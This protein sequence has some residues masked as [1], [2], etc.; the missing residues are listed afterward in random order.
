MTEL[1]FMKNNSSPTMKKKVMILF[2]HKINLEVNN[3]IWMVMIITDS[4]IKNLALKFFLKKKALKMKS[5]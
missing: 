5:C 2:C 3:Q 4:K 1:I